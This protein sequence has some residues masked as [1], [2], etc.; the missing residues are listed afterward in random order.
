MAVLGSGVNGSVMQ[1]MGI[2]GGIGADKVSADGK[3]VVRNDFDAHHFIRIKNV[4]DA[5]KA[6]IQSLIKKSAHFDAVLQSIEIE[7]PMG[8]GGGGYSDGVG[9]AQ[10]GK[11][12]A[13]SLGKDYSKVVTNTSSSRNGGMGGKNKMPDPENFN[14]QRGGGGGG[15]GGG[16]SDNYFNNNDPPRSK[17]KYDDDWRNQF[18]NL[19]V[20]SNAGK[21]LEMV[22]KQTSGNAS[23]PKYGGGKRG[24]KENEGNPFDDSPASSTATPTS[25]SST[26]T[27]TPAF[28]RSLE[29]DKPA[30]VSAR[31]EIEDETGP[32]SSSSKGTEG[33]V[34]EKKKKKKPTSAPPLGPPPGK[35]KR[36]RSKERKEKLKRGGEGE[37]TKG[38]T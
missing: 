35:P 6:Q 1:P 13:H 3:V 11:P 21:I 27:P 28:D 20:D 36:S 12:R 15:G 16:G 17:K 33:A 25:A 31:Q 10:M 2:S 4:N 23:Q 7:T 32:S 30:P 26:A 18:D 34:K 8:L 14:R 37:E 22:T 9:Y 24:G 38:L 19:K 5:V 29:G